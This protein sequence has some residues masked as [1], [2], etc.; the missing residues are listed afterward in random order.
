MTTER[1]RIAIEGVVQGVGFRPF[2]YV[3]AARHGV[4]GFVSNRAGDVVIEAEAPRAALDAFVAD[5]RGCAPAA[6]RVDRLIAT[7]AEVRGERGFSIESSEAGES[8]AAIAPDV[9]TCADCIAEIE[10]PAARRF[11]YAFTSCAA[12]GPRL[13]IVTSAPYD[14]ARTTMANFAMCA[15]CRAEYDDPIDRRFHAQPIA[16]PACGPTLDTPVAEAAAALRAGEIVALKGL[17]GYHLACD[18]LRDDAVAELR[19]RKQ[20]DGKPFAIMVGDLVAARALAE[21]T[22][23][24]EELLASPARPIVLVPAR[25]RLPAS[26]APGVADV[27]LMLPYTPLHHLLLRA[28]AGPLVMTSGNVSDEPLA[29]R[30]DDARARLAPI[31]D[32]FVTHDRPIHMRCD[33]SVVRVVAGAPLILRRARG[34]A[35]APIRLPVAVDRPTLALGGHIKAAF[36]LADGDRAFV[37]PHMG[38]LDHLCAYDAFVAAIEHFSALHR[39]AFERVICDRHPDY[40]TT[41]L[42]GELGREVIA[43]QHHRAHFASALADAGV[44]GR[45]IGVIFDGAGYGDDGAI[46]G[47]E[48]LV[49]DAG[50]ARRALHL[51]Y[52]PQPGGDAAAREPQRMAIAHLWAAG[53]PVDGPIAAMCARPNLAPR[54][55]SMGRLFDAVAAISGI[56]PQRHG[57]HGAPDLGGLRASVVSLFEGE[58]AMR[59]EALARRGD[60]TELYP[61]EISDDEMIVA[62]AIRAIAADAADGVP[63]AT[64]ARR[65]HTTV[66]ELAT[67]ACMRVARQERV[68]NVVLSGGVFQN[69][70]LAAELPRRLAS[71]GLTPHVHRRVP[72]NDGGLAFGQLAAIAGARCA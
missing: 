52:V 16:C 33:D 5:L 21:L 61:F 56:Q 32:R 41:R 10:D 67:A 8:A 68:T 1:L 66:V 54:T 42:A 58:A 3:L 63:A 69:A 17:G 34:Y 4:D 72:P 49:G 45:A 30:D 31:A 62:P 29:F 20:R 51:A 7:R 36:A 60:P 6:A 48:I 26:I 24:D 11:G 25:G 44:E 39:I 40:A 23:D 35:P 71:V 64:I 2:V 53:E 55:S 59:L 57:G 18:A 47:G 50:D 43:V 15:A 28:F 22:A 38:D 46:W 9:A 13:T 27:G 14:R 12:C 65:F 70:I 37:S 19:R